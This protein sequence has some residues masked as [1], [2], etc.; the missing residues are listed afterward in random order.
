MNEREANKFWKKVQRGAPNECWPWIGAKDPGGYGRFLFRGKVVKAHRLALATIVD[1][2]VIVAGR[3]GST[4]VVVL[5]TCD[6]PDCVNPAHLR[7]GAQVDNVRDAASKKRMRG[8]VG[9]THPMTSITDDQVAEIRRLYATGCWSQVSLAKA[10]G[11]KR[12]AVGN[13]ITGKSR[14]T[15]SIPKRCTRNSYRLLRNH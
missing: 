5:H 12:S 13:Y 1:V 15:T 10:F 8:P 3:L 2:D 9:Q 14:V 6:N 11:C 4:G 7:A